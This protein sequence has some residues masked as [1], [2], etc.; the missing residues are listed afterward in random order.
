MGVD[1]V[2]PLE[3]TAAPVIYLW[4]WEKWYPLYR[5]H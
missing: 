4:V 5:F 2:L 3:I 1:T